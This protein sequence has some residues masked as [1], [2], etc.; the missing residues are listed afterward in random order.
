MQPAGANICCKAS[1]PGRKANI[2]CISTPAGG[3]SRFPGCS[4]PPAPDCS[5]PQT[6]TTAPPALRERVPQSCDAQMTS[7]LMEPQEVR[8]KGKPRSCPMPNQEQLRQTAADP[9]V[10][11]LQP[12]PKTK[13][14]S[15][16]QRAAHLKTDKL[17]ANATRQ[18]MLCLPMTMR[19]LAHVFCQCAQ[20][21]N[22]A[23]QFCLISVMSN[24]Q[25]LL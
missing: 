2:W 18:T 12:K 7:R 10:G 6:C 17:T 1:A 21:H 8:V 5:R 13:L 20:T 22:K 3:R 15:V 4:P 23:F 11:D 25:E 16:P 14:A 19:F 9:R 24:L